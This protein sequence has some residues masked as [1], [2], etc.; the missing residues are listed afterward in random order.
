MAGNE[1]QQEK[2]GDWEIRNERNMA[3]EI[4][5]QTGGRKLIQ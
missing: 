4:Y 1:S 2:S 5:E 3:G